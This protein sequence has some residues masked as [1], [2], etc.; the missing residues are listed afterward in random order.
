VVRVADLQQGLE[1]LDA[2]APHASRTI[3]SDATVAP[4]ALEYVDGYVHLAD[5]DEGYVLFCLTL[6]PSQARSVGACQN[7]D[8]SRVKLH[9]FQF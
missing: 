2:T 3:V 1:A 8:S 7:R 9:A 4:H 5:Q 6:D